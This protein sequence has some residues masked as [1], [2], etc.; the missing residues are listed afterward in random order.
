M[1]AVRWR[2]TLAGCSVNVHLDG[3]ISLTHGPHRL[4]RYNAQGQPLGNDKMR[5]P[6]AAAGG[7]I[8]TG[9]VTC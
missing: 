2:G 9:H 6:R 3:T 8:Q 1:E 7:L 5:R 4:G